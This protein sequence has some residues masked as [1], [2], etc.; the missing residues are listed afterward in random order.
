MLVYA[1]RKAT[2]VLHAPLELDDDRFAGQ[3]IQEWLRVDGN[4]LQC[5]RDLS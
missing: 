3:L 2:F 4:S 5:M 1:A